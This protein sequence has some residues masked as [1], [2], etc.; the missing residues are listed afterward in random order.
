MNRYKWLSIKTIFIHHT[1]NSVV[2][3][4]KAEFTFF[5]S[6]FFFQEYLQF[7]GLQ[8]KGEA[9][10]LYLFCHFHTFHRHLDIRQFLL[11]RDHLCA[12]LAPELEQGVFG[13]QMQVTNH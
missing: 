7:T 3:C 5:L 1:P 9:I 6:G 10:S 8:Q 13:L 4:C 12:K 2:R 11:Q